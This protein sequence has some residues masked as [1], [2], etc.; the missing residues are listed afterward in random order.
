[1]ETSTTML[2]ASAA[3]RAV[4]REISV[5][6]GCGAKVLIT[7]ESGVGKELVA[8]LIHER[9][10]RSTAPF[11]PIN[12]AG[13]PDTLLE[14]ELFGHVR[15][16]FTGAYRD[17]RGHLEMAHKGTI[18]MDE[19]GEMSLRMQAMLLRFLETGEIQRVGADRVMPPL[20][21]RVIA[22]THRD[23]VARVADQSFREDLYYRLNVVHIEVPPLRDRREDISCLMRYFL[24]VFSNL[25][26]L[27]TPEVTPEAL[28]RLL[29]YD[30]PGN[31]REL[32]NVAERMVVGG[33]RG[34]VDVG[35]LPPEIGH[36]RRT[37]PA[38]RSAEPLGAQRLNRLMS[39]GLSF[40]S[41]VHEP[42]M[43]RDMTR[44]DVRQIVQAGLAYTRGNY[45]ML[46]R[47]FN[48]PPRD[49]KRF[50]S[51][52]RTHGCHVSY[53]SFRLVDRHQSSGVSAACA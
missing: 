1:M 27:P 26:R 23:L 29:T 35:T 3:M 40:W 20:D 28:Q 32:K 39:E 51:F 43:K 2:G 45:K 21:V 22:A 34:R 30:W 15:G 18:F 36:E 52:L 47:A 5:A 11:V 9:G 24:D 42:F 46:V 19:V 31:V 7:G 10:R 16:S 4:E 8:R 48:M 33:G 53:Q 49:Y 6:A 13:L 44:E 14:S 50:L 38:A 25:H 17:K 37:M 41:E 12:C